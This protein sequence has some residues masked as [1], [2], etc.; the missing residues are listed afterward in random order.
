MRGE[1]LSVCIGCFKRAD[2]YVNGCKVILCDLSGEYLEFGYK[3]NIV[4]RI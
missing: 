1:L 4:I 2:I 3:S